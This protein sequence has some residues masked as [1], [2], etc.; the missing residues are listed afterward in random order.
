MPVPVADKPASD[1]RRQ[2][3]SDDRCPTPPSTKDER[4]KAIE[5]LIA[6][7]ENARHSD[8]AGCRPLPVAV[9]P[10]KRHAADETQANLDNPAASRDAAP[11]SACAAVSIHRRRARP[12]GAHRR[13]AAV[14]PLPAVPAARGCC[15]ERCR[16]ARGRPRR[17]WQCRRFRWPA[18]VRRYCNRRHR[19]T[20][21]TAARSCRKSR[22]PAT[23]AGFR[24]LTE[25]RWRTSIRSRKSTR[26]ALVWRSPDGGLLNAG[27]IAAS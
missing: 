22:C 25:F 26:V 7:R 6:D 4:G 21:A 5:G 20:N 12:A 9:R 10:L 13:D 2:F 3:G 11:A 23:A 18:A 1:A 17:G 8:Q 16:P 14:T 15:T 27:A 19:A 24:S